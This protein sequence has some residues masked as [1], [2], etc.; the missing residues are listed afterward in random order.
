VAAVSDEYDSETLIDKLRALGQDDNAT[1]K[2]KEQV[3][4]IVEELG[5]T[6]DGLVSLKIK[7][8]EKD[9]YCY[10]GEI[11]LV[12]EAMKAKKRPASRDSRRRLIQ[13]EPGPILSPV[14]KT[15]QSSDL[16]QDHQGTTFTPNNSKRSLI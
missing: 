13:R 3:A 14:K 10:P 12:N 8:P 4:S 16:R 1:E 9:T 6:F 15:N 7:P 5:G 2:I 11:D